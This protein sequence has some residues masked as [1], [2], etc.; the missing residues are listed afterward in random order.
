MKV[1][2]LVGMK[3][4]IS[5]ETVAGRA[6]MVEAGFEVETRFLMEPQRRG[7]IPM[8][9]HSHSSPTF[10]TNSAETPIS[11][12]GAN[13]LFSLGRLQTDAFNAMLR[14]QIEALGFLKSRCE[15]DLQFL[16]EIWS[17]GHVNDSFDLWCC[18]WQKAFLDYS[19][20]AGRVADIGSNIAAKA[21][22]RIH[23]EPTGI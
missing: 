20:E 19:R 9:V 4:T 1:S 8:H 13:V 12:E 10:W 16:Q 21:A 17:P 15:Q 2:A 11:V 7:A 22:K 18:F 3:L 6:E 5:D 14:Y 23:G